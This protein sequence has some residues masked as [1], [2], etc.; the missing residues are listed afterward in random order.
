MNL[1]SLFM[2]FDK[3]IILVSKNLNN[4]FK[5]FDLFDLGNLDTCLN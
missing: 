2:D 5:D 1:N 3:N 4:I